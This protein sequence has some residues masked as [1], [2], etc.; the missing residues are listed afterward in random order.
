M[1]KYKE[2]KQAK[3]KRI[4]QQKQ[5]SLALNEYRKENEKRELF[6]LIKIFWKMSHLLYL[7]HYSVKSVYYSLGL[8]ILLNFFISLLLL[9]HGVIPRY[10]AFK[11]FII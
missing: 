4:A 11:P 10:L 9:P 5:Q 3:Q 1:A 8:I 2:N 7:R 6:F